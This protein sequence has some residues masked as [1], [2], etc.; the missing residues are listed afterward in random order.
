VTLGVATVLSLKA[1]D[2]TTAHVATGA[3][4]LVLCVL[5]TL[6]AVRLGSPALAPAP[7]SVRVAPRGVTA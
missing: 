5:S 2:L 4:L 6:H 7:G 3:L 1:V